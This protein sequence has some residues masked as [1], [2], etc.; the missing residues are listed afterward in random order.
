[1]RAPFQSIGTN[2]IDRRWLLLFGK[3]LQLEV[4]LLDGLIRC[5]LAVPSRHQE[6]A[7]GSEGGAANAKDRERWFQTNLLSGLSA[8]LVVGR[9]LFILVA[10]LHR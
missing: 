5:D 8:V 4:E 7:D 10:L 2:R 1:M 6:A 9:H 3:L